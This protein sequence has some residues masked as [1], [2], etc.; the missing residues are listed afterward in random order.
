MYIGFILLSLPSIMTTAYLL[1]ATS[2]ALALVIH[3]YVGNNYYIPKFSF[4][5]VLEDLTLAII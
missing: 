3:T 5:V 2:R 4:S 1:H